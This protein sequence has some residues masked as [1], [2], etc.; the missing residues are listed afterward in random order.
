MNEE[1][2]TREDMLDAGLE[3]VQQ[4]DGLWCYRQGLFDGPGSMCD[5]SVGG[6]SRDTAMEYAKRKMAS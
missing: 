1:N 2:P 3:V 4:S 5:T 6:L